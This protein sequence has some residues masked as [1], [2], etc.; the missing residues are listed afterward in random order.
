MSLASL[1]Q[2]SSNSHHPLLAEVA[3]A[4]LVTVQSTVAAF[5]LLYVPASRVELMEWTLLPMIGAT[6]AAGG[7]FCLN[8]QQE[9]R[10]I[11]IGRCL[12]ALMIGVV[13][14]RL[15]SMVHPWVSEILSDPLLKVGAGFACGGTGYIISQPLF[16]RA[17]DRAAP[18]AEQLV[19]MAEAKMVERISGKVASN[20]SHVA[21]G[22]AT[23][24]A[25]NPF[26]ETA[27]H[28]AEVVAQV[29]KQTVKVT[30]TP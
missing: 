29:S 14:P 8:T 2:Q 26:P 12:L 6:I 27:A 22:V 21:S 19:K 30:Q 17:Y 5:L 10:R 3:A 11:V 20:V 28:T 18:I 15:M 13:G 7:A 9:V 25:T 24:L 23:E 16:K 1:V 4:T